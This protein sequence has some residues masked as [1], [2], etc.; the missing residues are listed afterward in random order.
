[1]ASLVKSTEVPLEKLK[2]VLEP[3][4]TEANTFYV[5]PKAGGMVLVQIAYSTMSWSPSVQVSAAYHGADGSKKRHTASL[6][7]SSFRPAED[8]ISVTCENMSVQFDASKKSYHVTLN[9]APA[10]VIDFNFEAVD[11]FCQ[12]NEG[13][14]PFNHT[15]I[16]VGYVSAQFIPKGRVTGNVIVDGKLHDI[17]GTGLYVKA[18]QSKPQC[19]ARWSFANFQTEKDALLMYQYE[20]CRGYGYDF[21]AR[22]EGALV[23]DNKIVAV[24]LNNFATLLNKSYDSFSGYE[25]PSEVSYRWEGEAKDGRPVKIEMK[26]ALTHLLDKID[27][28]SELPFFVRKF[29]Q[30]C[31]TAPFVYQ[32]FEDASASVTIGEETHILKGKLFHENAFL[33]ALED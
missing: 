29:I 26:V 30:T 14:V 16:S 13:K 15:D 9:A 12:V 6:S 21:D 17:E 19:A 24:T 33:A 8:G 18:L 10:M 27:L 3:S 23:L 31:I 20:L 5:H 11:G 32:W 1:M 4:A 2:W 25:V 28:L 7:G 22:S